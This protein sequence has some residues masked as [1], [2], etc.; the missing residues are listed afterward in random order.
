MTKEEEKSF[1]EW[2]Q[3]E[4]AMGYLILDKGIV[5]QLKDA[6]LAGMEYERDVWIDKDS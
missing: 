1:K 5:Q 2:L 6:F 4:I 3:K